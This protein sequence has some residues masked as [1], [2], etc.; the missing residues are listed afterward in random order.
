MV[1]KALTRSVMIDEEQLHSCATG[2]RKLGSLRIAGLELA[3]RVGWL[4]GA[5]SNTFSD[6]C[7]KLAATFKEIR[8][9]GCSLRQ[10]PQLRGLALAPGQC[11]TDLLG[12]AR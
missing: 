4:P 3:A 5:S 12:D 2:E 9:R 11:A 6:R 7:R 8:A 1:P 10:S